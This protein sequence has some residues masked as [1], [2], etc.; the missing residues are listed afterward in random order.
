MKFCLIGKKLPYSYSALIH[1]KVGADY[2]VKEIE[3]SR[4]EGFVKSGE[5]DGFNVTI[6]YKT[7]IIP[8]LTGIDEQAKKIGSVNTVYKKNGGIYGA[9]TDVFG[10]E[11]AFNLSGVS[12][13]GKNAV[14]LGSGGTSKTAQFFLLRNGAKSVNIVSRTGA[15]NYDNCYT[16]LPDAEILINCTPVGTFP[17]CF[18]V[19]LNVSLFKK[20]EFVFDCVYN[21]LNTS[22]TLAA[23]KRGIKCANGLSMLVAQALKAE[24]IWTGKPKTDKIK[25]LLSETYF[26]KGN[27]VLFGMPSSGKTVIGER[28]ASKLNRKFI[29]TDRVI[30]ERTGNKPSEIIEKQGEKVFRKI[31]TETIKSLAMVSGAVISVGGGAV[32]N[33]EN[34]AA[35][36]LNGTLIY[37]KRDL[38]CLVNDG[39]PLSQKYGAEMLFSQR[40]DIYEGVKDVEIIN[41]ASIESAVERVVI[42]Y[43]NSC[44]KR[45]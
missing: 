15:I 14:I 36:K 3:P 13:K 34:V 35:L 31:E 8:F 6:P 39:R 43:E 5:F 1:Q 41:D 37:V 30:E 19:P 40:K 16:L 17:D 23:K 24:E 7:E 25:Q 32:I 22:L 9:N 27:I 11:Y 42:E 10:M 29:D 28:V 21:P 33:S 45:C 4:L 2:C 12:V 44:N 26:E 20:L 18:G 38:K